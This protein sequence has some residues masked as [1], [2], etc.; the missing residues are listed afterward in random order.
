MVA[1]PV[2]TLVFRVP[3]PPQP[4]TVSSAERSSGGAKIEVRMANV[5]AV[6]CA[7]LP[8]MDG[9]PLPQVVALISPIPERVAAPP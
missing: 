9:K 1:V 3:L 2:G 6:G 7:Y 5:L 8:G 4:E